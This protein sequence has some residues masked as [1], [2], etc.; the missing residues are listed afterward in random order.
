V[1]GDAASGTPADPVRVIRAAPD[2]QRWPEL[3]ALL[4]ARIDPPSSLHKMDTAALAAKAGAET[5]LLALAG[6]RLLGCLFA[7]PLGASLYVGKF[8]VAPD[9][10]GQGIGR[11]LMH[12]AEV[13]AREHGLAGIELETRIELV[14]NH[15][16]FQALGF[17]KIAEKSHPG[18]DRPTSITMHKHV[19][20]VG[21]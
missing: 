1:T 16:T 11:R 12:A 18:Y 6:E 13:L 21:A 5:L 8:A 9:A 19:P 17:R 10:Q 14:E 2:F 15:A 7:R 4:H 20:A 3:L